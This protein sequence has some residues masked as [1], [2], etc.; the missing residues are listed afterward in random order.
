M[1]QQGLFQPITKWAVRAEALATLP[2]IICRALRVSTTGTP[3]PVAVIVSNPLWAAEGD[4]DLPTEA[5]TAHHPAF[6]VVPG[7]ESVEQATQL[8]R[9][10]KRPAI[11]AGGGVMLAQAA[12]DL[13]DL[14]EL[15]AIPVATTHVA[16]GTFPSAHLLSLG[17]L[18]NPVAGS[19]RRI[20]NKV[21]GEAEGHAR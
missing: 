20:A 18:G 11:V 2:D 19:R 14:A 5:E 3:G 8:L 1:D 4:F 17:V 10:A 6:R 21:V 13:I 12:R 15:M 7:L 16:H 9:E